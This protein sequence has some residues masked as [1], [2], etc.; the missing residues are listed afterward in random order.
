[1]CLSM[2]FDGFRKHSEA[3]L[4]LLPLCKP[5]KARLWAL[6]RVRRRGFALLLQFGSPLLTLLELLL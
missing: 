3:F 1:M 5:C 2:V 6:V 4:P